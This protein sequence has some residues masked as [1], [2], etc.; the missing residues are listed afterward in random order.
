M[1][2]PSAFLLAQAQTSPLVQFIYDLASS[3]V[4]FV[5]AAYEW[6]L[7]GQCEHVNDELP[8]L[9]ARL[10][11]DDRA[12]LAASW[13]RW[14]RNEL[15]E[16]VVFRLQVPGRP[17]QWLQLTPGYQPRRARLDEQ[18]AARH[19]RGPTLQGPR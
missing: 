5:N 1:L 15:H 17:E 8:G 4:I 16:E 2:D 9:L 13:G 14:T 19:Q 12:H 10:H 7:G 6:M 18:P 11:P 3:R